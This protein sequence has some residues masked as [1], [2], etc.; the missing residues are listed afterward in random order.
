MKQSIIYITAAVLLMGACAKEEN[1]IVKPTPGDE[2][3][4]S[5]QLSA[6]TQTKTASGE[7]TDTGIK[8]N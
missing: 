3:R 5:G 1:N 7:E 4:F 2:V 8:V 6:G